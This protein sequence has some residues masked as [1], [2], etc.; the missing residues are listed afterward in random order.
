MMSTDKFNAKQLKIFREILSSSETR[1]VDL[2]ICRLR[3]RNREV[4]RWD[5]HEENIFLRSHEC[6]L[7]H[8]S[9]I[10]TGV[11]YILYLYGLVLTLKIKH[12]CYCSGYSL[13]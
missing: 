5:D 11:R 10:S 4:E 2:M 9:I 3:K 1:S 12:I 8:L 13:K 7:S 6:C